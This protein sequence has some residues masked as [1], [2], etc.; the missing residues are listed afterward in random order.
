MLLSYRQNVLYLLN[1]SP[2]Y[3][4]RNVLITNLHTGEHLGDRPITS[5]G[6]PCIL[7]W[8]TYLPNPVMNGQIQNDDVHYN[9]DVITRPSFHHNN[10]NKNINYIL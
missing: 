7:R 4:V 2:I 5:N 3:N 10:S 8:F 6:K 9:Q 1:C